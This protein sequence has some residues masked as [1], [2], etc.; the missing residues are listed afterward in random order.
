[1]FLVKARYL[2]RDEQ[3]RRILDFSDLESFGFG[4]DKKGNAVT[5]S[6][7][8]FRGE[9]PK[10]KGLPLSS[11]LVFSETSLLVSS[12]LDLAVGHLRNY[13]IIKTDT[14]KDINI[15][16]EIEMERIWTDLK[17]YM[18]A[19][20]RK[21]YNLLGHNCCTVSTDAFREVLGVVVE[22]L[23]TTNRGIGTI[24]K[25]SSILCSSGLFSSLDSCIDIDADNTG[26]VV[27]IM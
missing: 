26:I 25:G 2:G 15:K 10:C 13:K 4:Q 22:L 3:G 5:L 24:F 20:K 19:Q 6:E 7:S 9:N 8:I 1:M 21:G 14:D 16:L 27:D 17:T 18:I 12:E 11:Q 23:T